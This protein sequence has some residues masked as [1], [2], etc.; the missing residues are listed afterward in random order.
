MVVAATPEEIAAAVYGGAPLPAE[1]LE[2]DAAVFDRFTT[3]FDLP[4]KAG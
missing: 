1:A 4:P 3:F 2:G